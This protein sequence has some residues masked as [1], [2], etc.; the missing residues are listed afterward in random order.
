MREFSKISPLVWRDKRFRSL[1]TSDARLVYLFLCTCEHQNSGGCYRMPDGYAAA[2]LGWDLQRFVDARAQVV[3]AGLVVFDPCTMELCVTGW[4][5]LNPAMNGKHSQF[6]QRVIA[7]IESDEVRE[8]A[9]AAFQAS[10]DFK[11]SLKTKA[12][13]AQVHNLNERLTGSRFMNRGAQ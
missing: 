8:T 7:S 10:E 6:I 3:D 2:D 12:P 13:S 11:K 4:F 5:D 9:E 1:P